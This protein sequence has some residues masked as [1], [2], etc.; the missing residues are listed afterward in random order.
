MV[1]SSSS[2]RIQLKEN[3]RP[4]AGGFLY[5]RYTAGKHACLHAYLPANAKSRR[6]G[7]PLLLDY[8]GFLQINLGHSCTCFCKILIGG[9]VYRAPRI[10]KPNI[11]CAPQDDLHLF[12]LAGTR[13]LS[14][15]QNAKPRL[16]S[17]TAISKALPMSPLLCIT[18]GAPCTTCAFV[19]N[20]T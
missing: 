7:F 11:C 4:D 16:C 17:L 10:C 18:N 13:I 20:A 3:P 8:V 19:I 6:R 12:R 5:M 1:R 9:N 14:I 2:S 15:F